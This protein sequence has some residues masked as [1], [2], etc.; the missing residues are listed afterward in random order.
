M[1]VAPLF[2]GAAATIT[3]MGGFFAGGS[4]TGG[5][6]VGEG[7]SSRG[8]GGSSGG[9]AGDGCMVKA[10]HASTPDGRF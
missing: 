1:R 10:G 8:G 6:S 2:A 9:T 4:F 3:V 7:G 5:S